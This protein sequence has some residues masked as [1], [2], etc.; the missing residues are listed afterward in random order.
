[1]K[2][3]KVRDF[4]I[5]HQRLLTYLSIFA[6][7]V[8]LFKLVYDDIYID[9]DN[10]IFL[11]I[12]IGI[13]VLCT[14]ASYLDRRRHMLAKFILESSDYVNLY[15]LDLNF[16]YIGVNRNDVRLMQEI[17]GFTPK[18]GESPMQYLG[19]E[20]A[21]RLKS[22]VDR[23]KKGE[24]FTFMDTIKT[25]DKTLYWENLYSPIYDNKKEI[26][27][28]FCIVLD[29]TEQRLKE[30]EMQRLAY[31]D[32]LTQVYNR[33]YI[34]LAYNECVLNKTQEITVI[35]ADLDKFKE[36]NDTYGH[37]KGDEILVKFGE[38]LTQI[39]PQK[40][41]VAR[42]GGD[43]FAVLLPG[44]SAEQANFLMKLIQVDMLFNNLGVTVSLGAYTDSY[45]SG[46]SFME[47][48]SMADK[49]MYEDKNQKGQSR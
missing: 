13:L 17:F 19:K 30:L 44:V 14:V 16:R 22:N 21:A 23:A 15:A 28:V 26:I 10:P 2:A 9:H 8:L 6:A 38:V 11:G 12:L 29:V 18:Y 36:A 5:K 4:L 43:E 31:E 32:H 46:K 25:G 7:F 41:T 1:M 49:R 27:G 35:M 40:A 39:M 34:E 20:E 42:L 45:Q 37:A 48:C 47:F 24:T 3:V 33:R